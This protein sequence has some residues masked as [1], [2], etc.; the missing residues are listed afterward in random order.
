MIPLFYP[1][2]RYWEECSKDITDVLKGRW[3]GQAYKVDEFESAFSDNFSYQFCLAVNSGSAALELAYDLIDIQEGDE[4]IT[5]VLTCTATNIPLIRR[6]AQI[7]FSDIQKEDFI[8]DPEDVEKKITDKTKAIVAVTLGG[9]K[10]SNKVFE[11]ANHHQIPVVVDA[12]QSLGVSE[13]YGDYIIYSF[14]AIKHFSTGDGGM[15]I[16][17]NESEYDKAK[18]LRWFGID[19]DKKKASDWQAYKNREMTIDIEQ[20]GYKFHMNDI[21]ASLGLVGL[22]HSDEILKRRQEIVEY[23][24]DKLNNCEKIAG[25]ACWLY[26]VLINNRDENAKDF[27]FNHIDVNMVHLRNDIYT[28]FSGKRQNLKNMNYIENKYLYIPLNTYMSD[29][30]VDQVVTVF[31]KIIN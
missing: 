4:V 5:P 8:I 22:K 26:G 31:N 28:V 24:N 30:D 10:I 9:L 25:G 17:R 14:Q 16:V 2:N 11:I 29:S 13:P 3:W 23:Y 18:Q 12:A 19:R 20:P 27:L 7:I 21:A 6:K 15:L 1:E